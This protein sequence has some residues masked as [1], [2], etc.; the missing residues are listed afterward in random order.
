M[1][2]QIVSCGIFAMLL[3]ASCNGA[4]QTSEVDLIDIAGG[5]EKLS[6]TTKGM[7]STVTGVVKN[8]LAKIVG[9]MDDGTVRQ[10]SALDL[11]RQKISSLADTLVKWQNDGTIEAIADKAT[12][13]LGKALDFL[14][15]SIAWVKDNANWLIPVL[16]GLV[17][18]FAAFNILSTVAKLWGAY[19]TVVTGVTAAQGALNFI[20]TANPIGLV[21]AASHRRAYRCRRSTL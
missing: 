14:G 9:I 3:L 15:K 10:G 12:N 6:T 4:Q 1:K 16:S 18:T 11:V 20:M 5:M 19:Q 2:R 8:S 21:A 7:W 13:V 17:A